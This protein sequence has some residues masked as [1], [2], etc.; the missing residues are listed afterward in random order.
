MATRA[1][2]TRIAG[3]DRTLFVGK[4][5]IIRP[6][7]CREPIRAVFRDAIAFAM[8]RRAMQGSMPALRLLAIATVE[9]NSDAAASRLGDGQGEKVGLLRG[10]SDRKDMQWRR[11]PFASGTT[12]MPKLLHASTPR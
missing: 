8:P 5:A 7:S 2:A 9:T 3:T 1:A 11:T 12:R 10:A 4:L 6:S